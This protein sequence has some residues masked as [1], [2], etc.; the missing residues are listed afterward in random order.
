MQQQAT[1]ILAKLP[2][3]S[4]KNEPMFERRNIKSIY[5]Q[6]TR[7]VKDFLLSEKS[8]EFLFFLFFFLIAGGFW[9]LQTLND[10]YET[11]LSIPVRLKDVPND[12][13]ITSEPPSEVYVKIKDKGTVLLN[14]LLTKNFLPIILDFSDYQGSGNHV[15]ILPSQ[16]EKRISSQ[17]NVSTKLLS[18]RPDT[19]EYIYA[20]GASKQLPVKFLGSVNAGRQYYISDTICRPDSVLAYAPKE[21]LDTMT[22]AYTQF[23]SLKDILDTV[24]LELPLVTQKGV[25]FFPETVEMAFPVDIYTEKTVE[26]PLYGTN[27]P[28]DKILRTFPSK[29][30]VTFQVGLSRFRQIDAN[31]FRINVSYEELLKLDSDKYTVKLKAY[32]TAAKQIRIY[33]EQVDFLI[34]QTSPHYGN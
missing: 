29:V 10:D 26:V 19:L 20:T 7:K 23:I 30:S 27:F 15:R 18:V 3:N 34:E 9:L 33:P 5:L 12:I 21:V 32:P 6:F 16:F 17:L 13:V 28:T 14:Y 11:E 2:N 22:A 8:R 4:N 24:K 25:K 1:L 31:D